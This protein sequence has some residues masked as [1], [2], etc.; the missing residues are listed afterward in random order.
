MK[1]SV[2]IIGGGI[3]GSS[4]AYFLAR[5][6]ND[7]SVAVIEKDSSYSNATT[8]QGA[9]GCVNNSQSKRTLRSPRSRWVFTNIGRPI[10]PTFPT[11]QI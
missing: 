6:G 3:I 10:W 5:A 11:S 9:G 2:A 7:V 1:Y 8:S 4:A